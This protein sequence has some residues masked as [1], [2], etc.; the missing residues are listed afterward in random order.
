MRYEN[1]A[2][3]QKISYNTVGKNQ[4]VIRFTNQ[5]GNPQNGNRVLIIT[6]T[7]TCYCTAIAVSYH[8]NPTFIIATGASFSCSKRTN[9]LTSCLVHVL[10]AGSYH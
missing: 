7:Y 3:P 9:K 2:S 5:L 10:H 1:A 8:Y 4:S 6:E